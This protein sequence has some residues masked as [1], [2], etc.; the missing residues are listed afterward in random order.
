M[1]KVAPVA[2]KELIADMNAGRVKLNDDGSIT[3]QGKTYKK[4]DSL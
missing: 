4:G 3:Y 1:P 2:P